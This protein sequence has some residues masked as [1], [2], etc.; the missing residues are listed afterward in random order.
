VFGKSGFWY[1]MDR[2]YVDVWKVSGSEVKRN[3]RKRREEV[4]SG[5]R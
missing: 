2:G 5:G 1:K 3:G 4:G